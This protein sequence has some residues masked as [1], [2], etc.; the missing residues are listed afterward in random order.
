VWGVR[1]YRLKNLGSRGIDEVVAV[2]AVGGRSCR[3]D[4]GGF[5]VGSFWKKG[6]ESVVVVVSLSNC[7]DLKVAGKFGVRHYGLRKLD[8]SPSP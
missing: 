7:L 1:V 8:S 5:I 4:R 2:V 6:V 3:R